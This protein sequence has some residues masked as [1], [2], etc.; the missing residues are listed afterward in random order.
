MGLGWW[1]NPVCPCCDPIPGLWLHLVPSRNP[2]STGM[3]FSYN[4]PNGQ[5]LCLGGGQLE[6]CSGV[7]KIRTENACVPKYNFSPL[8][9]SLGFG[10]GQFQMEW[11]HEVKL[12]HF[13]NRTS[14]VRDSLHVIDM[15]LADVCHD[16]EF[17][18]KT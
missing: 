18:I 6:D 17:E 2:G 15:G 5:W 1:N 8:S 11:N 12:D 14:L 7:R 9:I 4:H 16:G 3:Y 10:W 13:M